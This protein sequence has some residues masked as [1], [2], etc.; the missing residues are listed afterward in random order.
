MILGTNLGGKIHLKE[1]VKGNPC[2]EAEYGYEVLECSDYQTINE[3]FQVI[4]YDGDKLLY[5]NKSLCG[6][7]RKALKSIPGNSDRLYRCVECGEFKVEP[8]IHG[9]CWD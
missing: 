3:R 7:C 9:G 5:I 6:I 2:C 4:L 1:V 8:P